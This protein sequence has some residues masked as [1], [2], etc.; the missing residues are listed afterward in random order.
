MGEGLSGGGGV[1]EKVGVGEGGGGGVSE[2]VGG[3]TLCGN[4]TK[5]AALVILY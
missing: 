1:R 3:P 2:R 5:Y 4:R